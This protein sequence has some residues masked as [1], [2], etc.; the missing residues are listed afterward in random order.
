MLQLF[1]SILQLASQIAA[2]IVAGLKRLYTSLLLGEAF[3]GRTAM[4]TYCSVVL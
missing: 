1:L 2:A 4:K 3:A